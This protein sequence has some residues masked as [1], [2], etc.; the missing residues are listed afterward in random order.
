MKHHMP[1]IPGK[2]IDLWHK[3]KQAVS[4]KTCLSINFFHQY[5]L[6]PIN[7]YFTSS[8]GILWKNLLRGLVTNMEVMY[9]WMP[10]DMHAYSVCIWKV[11]IVCEIVCVCEISSSCLMREGRGVTRLGW[12]G[13]R[14]RQRGYYRIIVNSM[15]R[16]RLVPR[17]TGFWARPCKWVTLA[18]I[19]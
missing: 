1:C 8:L 13:S 9:T 10:C 7:V 6:T 2:H 19:G 11:V 18:S 14:S 17:R 16:G 3:P 5:S 4:Q 15:E 12:Q